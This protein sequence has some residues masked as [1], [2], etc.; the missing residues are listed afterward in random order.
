MSL[1]PRALFIC[2]ATIFLYKWCSGFGVVI[3]L[4]CTV[5]V[6][7]M[8]YING[9]RSPAQYPDPFALKSRRVLSRFC[10]EIIQPMESWMLQWCQGGSIDMLWDRLLEQLTY[11]H[12]TR[13]S[14]PMCSNWKGLSHDHFNPYSSGPRGACHVGAGICDAE[15]QPVCRQS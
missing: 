4:D 5:C 13:S 1:K 9:P 8:L 3:F 10:V 12:L 14:K 11:Q 6:K 7:Q 15:G 2:F